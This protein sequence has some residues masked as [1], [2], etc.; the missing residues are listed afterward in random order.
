[1]QATMATAA[2]E[3]LYYECA[4]SKRCQYGNW[5]S[6]L[7]ALCQTAS[8]L[9]A[10]EFQQMLMFHSETLI[11]LHLLTSHQPIPIRLSRRRGGAHQH[12]SRWN[13][14]TI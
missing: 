13:T 2:L 10:S 6:T 14:Q 9:A 8:N 12:V 11:R 5:P 7:G 1:M 4:C 3:V